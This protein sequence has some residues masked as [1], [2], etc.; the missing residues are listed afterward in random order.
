MH[1][2]FSHLAVIRTLQLFIGASIVGG[3]AWAFDDVGQ[4]V[5]ALMTAMGASSPSS[6]P[7]STPVFIA[8]GREFLTHVLVGGATVVF[9]FAVLYAIVQLCLFLGAMVLALVGCV[10]GRPRRHEARRRRT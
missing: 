8:R 9:A 4:K 6:W 10:W 5:M 7:A 2:L 3:L 1:K